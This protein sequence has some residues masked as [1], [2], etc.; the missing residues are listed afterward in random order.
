[1][2]S[3]KANQEKAEKCSLQLNSEEKSS[4]SCERN[5]TN[6][7][8]RMLSPAIREKRIQ[9]ERGRVSKNTGTITGLSCMDGT[10][11]KN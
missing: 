6:Q 4:N 10:L 3:I 11:E 9:G 2:A 8:F 5:G 7:Q 1:M